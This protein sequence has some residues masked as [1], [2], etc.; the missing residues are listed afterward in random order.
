MNIQTGALF[1]LPTRVIISLRRLFQFAVIW[2]PR[3]AVRYTA[4]NV[5]SLN[6]VF[7][8]LRTKL[9]VLFQDPVRTAQ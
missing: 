1:Y 4:T 2:G 3:F 9:D 6:T 7:N 8:P 5:W